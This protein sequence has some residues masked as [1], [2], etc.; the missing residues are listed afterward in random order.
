MAP[1]GCFQSPDFMGSCN[2]ERA[3][4]KVT[5]ERILGGSQRKE[6]SCYLGIWN[7]QTLLG[8][9]E[10]LACGGRGQCAAIVLFWVASQ[11]DATSTEALPS[12]LLGLNLAYVVS[13]E[14]IDPVLLDT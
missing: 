10:C 14:Y 7:H 2:A 1:D 12:P 5:A 6:A 3:M 8:S 11:E 9:N 4:L 13:L